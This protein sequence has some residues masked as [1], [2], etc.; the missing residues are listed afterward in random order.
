[1]N[2]T[3][4]HSETSIADNNY[5][6]RNKEGKSDDYQ[7]NADDILLAKY[8]PVGVIVNDRFDIVQF[9]GYTREYLESSPGKAS[10]N[11]LKMAKEGLV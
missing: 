10:L 11:V 2:V 4:G 5:F 7:K 1:M 6:L 9:R 3:S 8:T